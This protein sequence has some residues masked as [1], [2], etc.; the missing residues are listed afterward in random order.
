MKLALVLALA[1]G[2]SAQQHHML[3]AQGPTI[4]LDRFAG[5]DTGAGPLSYA[6]L[7]AAAR[8]L[9]G[10]FSKYDHRKLP[11]Q[12][13]E[14]DGK[15]AY[16]AAFDGNVVA[17]RSKPDDIVAGEPSK[18]DREVSKYDRKL[19]AV[20]GEHSKLDDIVEGEASEDARRRAAEKKT[21]AASSCSGLSK[22]ECKTTDGCKYKKKKDK[23][24]AK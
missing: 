8:T 4:A 23:C 1:P 2:V 16:Q 3:G 10:K 20:A 9:D 14:H 7:P 24:L 17:E 18:L 5:F 12:Q 13:S 11:A 19:A 21:S 6:E 15:A 22:R